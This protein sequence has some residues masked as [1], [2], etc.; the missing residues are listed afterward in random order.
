MA[1]LQ[2]LTVLG[3]GGDVWEK[4]LQ[5]ILDNHGR[6]GGLR[7][8][9]FVATEQVFRFEYGGFIWALPFM[10]GRAHSPKG[11][12]KRRGEV[13]VGQTEK[14]RSRGSGR[15]GQAPD[16]LWPARLWHLLF[17]VRAWSPGQGPCCTV[18]YI[19]VKTPMNKLTFLKISTL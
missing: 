7:P 3:V 14:G 5:G 12:I 13:C 16:G 4:G 10:E 9:Y 11:V 6:V 2:L 1:S 18:P 19:S 8:S 17:H 15:G